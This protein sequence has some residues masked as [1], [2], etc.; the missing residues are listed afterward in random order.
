M[1]DSIV[2]KVQAACWGDLQWFVERYTAELSTDLQRGIQ[3]LRTTN[4]AEKKILGNCRILR[5]VRHNL[6][7]RYPLTEEIGK[8]L[9]EQIQKAEIQAAEFFLAT[10]LPTIKDHFMEDCTDV[11]WVR[12]HL[13][14]KL[15]ILDMKQCERFVRT[16]HHRTCVECLRALLMALRRLSSA[17][18][19]DV[20]RAFLKE[21]QQMQNLFK[22]HL[23]PGSA[24]L[25]NPIESTAAILHAKDFG[26]LKYDVLYLI[27]A[28]PDV[29]D[30]HLCTLVD[31]NTSV[32]R[33]EKKAVLNLLQ[34][35]EEP[36][37]E[38]EFLFFEDIE[39]GR[40][41]LFFCLCCC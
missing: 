15:Q 17:E 22:K 29:R 20:S 34:N 32:S 2:Q 9:E 7:E 23:G 10:H 33:K 39:L 27:T 40:R 31:S 19:K 35:R 24:P 26:A 11:R 3:A 4:Q 5:T 14:E 41:K 37:E 25:I 36:T 8:K 6:A 21:G 38:S 18:Q 13:E 28:H 12:L 16:I 1:G 30:E